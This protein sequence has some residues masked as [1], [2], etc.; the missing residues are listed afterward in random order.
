MANPDQIIMH[1][2][3]NLVCIKAKP[4]KDIVEMLRGHFYKHPKTLQ[5]R[6]KYNQTLPNLLKE[7]QSTYWDNQYVTLPE[8]AE[9]DHKYYVARSPFHKS[10]SITLHG[11]TTAQLISFSRKYVAKSYDPHLKFLS[12]DQYSRITAH[13]QSL[14]IEDGA[15]LATSADPNDPREFQYRM[16]LCEYPELLLLKLCL[17]ATFQH[18]VLDSHDNVINIHMLSG[19]ILDL[20]LLSSQQSILDSYGLPNIQPVTIESF[21]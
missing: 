6:P 7:V 20:T 5:F 4:E 9:I 21:F 10:Y 15:L 18:T 19:R 8:Y 13:N 16:D 2:G 17:L 11:V 1:N 12:G 14:V 3:R